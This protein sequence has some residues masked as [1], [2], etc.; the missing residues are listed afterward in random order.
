[1]SSCWIWSFLSSESS[2]LVYFNCLVHRF[3]HCTRIAVMS[4]P[5]TKRMRGGEFDD[6]EGDRSVQHL[7]AGDQKAVAAAC[8]DR[9]DT[10]QDQVSEGGE[11]EA[12]TRCPANSAG[13]GSD[14]DNGKGYLANMLVRCKICYCTSHRDTGSD[15]VGLPFQL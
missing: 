3:L 12:A 11:K 14:D 6:T 7:H 4:G 15:E 1:M 8:R 9:L 13:G 2:E 5:A 10:L